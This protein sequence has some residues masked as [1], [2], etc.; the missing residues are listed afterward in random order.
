[1]TI[2]ISQISSLVGRYTNEVVNEQANLEAPMVGQGVIK[3]LNKPDK[4]GIVNVKAGELNSVQFIGDA[5]TLPTGSDVQPAQG[6]YNPIG[7]FGRISIPRIAASVA[8][9]LDDGIDIV[10]EEMESCGRALGRQLGRGI[11]GSSLG[12]PAA[13]VTAASTS[14]TVA[15]PSPWRVGMAFEV[16]NGSSAIEG[17]AQ[18]TL[19]YVTNVSIPADGVGNSTI[20][21]VG[22][23]SGGNA[24]QWETTYTFY[25]RGS[26]ASASRMTSLADVTAASSL[27]GLANTSNEWSGSLDSSSTALTIPAMRALL[28]TVVRRRGKKPSHV[29]VNRRNAQRYSDQL[30]NN[31]R[32]MQGKMDA[33]GGSAY[34]FE[35]IQVFEDENCGDADLFYFNDQDVKLHVFKD[36]APDVDGAASKGMNRSA[37]LVSDSSL[38]YDVQVLGIFNLRA[39]RRSGIGRMSAIA[40]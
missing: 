4:I 17:N 24:S 15:D 31:R 35:G 27:Y 40:G 34:E 1:M 14:F 21:F 23:N 22:T 5:G 29:I 12:S 26:G 28:T 16:Y 2:T 20:T 11:F 8:S 39:E 7:L 18:A 3:K 32:F 9:S 36:F 25:L 38:V 37:V 19:L 6:T 13:Q 33:V 10:K 30:L